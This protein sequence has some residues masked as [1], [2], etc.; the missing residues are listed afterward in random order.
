[1][2]IKIET[3]SHCCGC[4][5]CASVCP[6]SA[7]G[8]I[9]DERGFKYPQVDAE[10]CTECGLCE[11]TCQLNKPYLR[12]DNY[13]T[14]H[15]YAM[16]CLDTAQLIR[17]QSGGAFYL[18]SEEILTQGGVIYGATY[19]DAFRIE[20]IR[21]T[22]ATTRDR[23]RGSKYVQSN[24][25]GI[26]RQ[27]KTDVRQGRA[28]LFSGTPCQVA[29]LRAIFGKKQPYNLIT[30][31]LLCHG[32]VSPEFW[33]QYLNMIAK[34]H[35]R[36]ITEVHMRDKTYGWLSSEETYVLGNRYIHKN[37]FYSLYYNG[38]VS[39]ES[40]YECPFANDLRVGDISIGDFRG[41]NDTHDQFTD[42]TGISIVLANSD[43]GQRLVDAVANKS[44]VYCEPQQVCAADHVA[45][46]KHAT[47]A[48]R[49]DDFW[50]DFSRNGAKYVC[51]QYGDMAW[52]TQLNIRI[53]KV[54]RKIFK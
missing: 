10:K 24:L 4:T 27:V 32:V 35:R 22:D 9:A 21:A 45:L 49:F 37:T 54:L 15:Y 13:D 34:S 3:P 47:R 38:Y 33:H 36:E 25:T 2:S 23:M 6:H 41:W 43:K 17:S 44:G 51:Q 48:S 26:F 8:M 18:L 52:R 11:M 7:I 40:C 31:D 42:N 5:A 20:H 19:G 28:V 39:R 12:Y 50:C 1:M 46:S 16:R 14:P 29:G 53:H 30:V